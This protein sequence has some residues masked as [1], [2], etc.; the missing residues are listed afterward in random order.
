MAIHEEILR[1]VLR[2]C[3]ERRTWTFKTEEVV[4]RLPHLN[5]SSVRT[6]IISRCCVNAPKNHPHKWDYFERVRRGLYAVRPRYRKRDNARR[7]AT[8][9]DRCTGG[10][11][12]G[13]TASP[14]YAMK[15]VAMRETIHAV[16][17]FDQ[18]V[19]VGECHEI[20]V[21]T[22]GRTLDE[23]V[24]NLQEAVSL[25]LDGENLSSI[26]ICNAPRLALT[27]EIAVVRHVAQT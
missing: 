21:V 22:Q 27:Y 6:H 24:S 4:L 2:L 14:Y 9:Q 7:V 20:S 10:Q 3:R 12:I 11:V 25:H 8:K 1:T 19:Y 15:P 17:I 5:E 13:E 18:G 16:V 26:G 23:L